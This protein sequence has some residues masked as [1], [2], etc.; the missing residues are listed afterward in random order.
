ML[1]IN[2]IAP[3]ELTIESKFKFRCYPGIS[4]YKSCCKNIDIMLTPYD[5]LRLKN[6]FDIS[7]GEFLMNYTYV[8]IEPKSGYPFV[9]LNK[10]NDEEMTCPFL[11]EAGCSVYEDRPATCRYYPVGQASLKKFDLTDGI[12]DEVY[13]FV[14]EPHCKGFQE[15]KE[16][17]VAEWRKDQGVDLYDDMNRGWKELFFKKNLKADKIDEKK[18]KAFYTAC[19]DIDAFKRFVFESRFMDVFD[20]PQERIEKM[21][22]DEVELMNFAFDYVKFLLMIKETLKLKKS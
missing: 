22:K 5:I 7:S 18:Q 9:F 20:V 19:Y 13:F 6:R 2:V 14:K 15:D 8:F 11:C 1:N 3:D 17:S 10:N 4:C 12:T 21:K 16:W